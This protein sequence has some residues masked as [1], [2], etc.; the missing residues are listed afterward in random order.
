MTL[1]DREWEER[2]RSY[3]DIAIAELNSLVRKH[4][5][6]APYAVRRPYYTRD[7]ELAKAYENCAEE[8]VR[9]VEQGSEDVVCSE[10]KWMS[11]DDTV[12]SSIWARV[13]H[14]LRSWFTREQ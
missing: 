1:R 6:L 7:T 9:G 4:N 11:V 3:H 5:A 12:F 14:W 8:I 13:L 2:E 10:N